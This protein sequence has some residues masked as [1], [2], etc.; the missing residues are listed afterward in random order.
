MGKEEKKLQIRDAIMPLRN[1]QGP[2]P[3]I[4]FGEASGNWEFSTALI[5]CREEFFRQAGLT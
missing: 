1:V 4:L 5:D 3:G 2:N